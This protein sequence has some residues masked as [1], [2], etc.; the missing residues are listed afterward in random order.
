MLTIIKKTYYTILG[1]VTRALA[2]WQVPPEALTGCGFLLSVASAALFWQGFFPWAGVLLLAGGA[3]DSLDG[4]VARARG[5]ATR[6]GAFLDST[7]D[8][9]SEVLVLGGLARYYTLNHND[10]MVMI[11]FALLAAA[12]LVSYVRARAEGV[13]Q[14]C[15]VGLLQRPGRV[16][17][18][19]CGALGGDRG[20]A[21][22]L[23][24]GAVLSAYTVLQRLIHVGRGLRSS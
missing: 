17:L 11:T 18:L 12:L 14:T 21:V 8:R 10:G 6:F 7:L 19:G 9:F 4:E 23:A 3:C 24:A 2:Q 13:G 1:P 15:T 22:A 16:V 20:M 5:R